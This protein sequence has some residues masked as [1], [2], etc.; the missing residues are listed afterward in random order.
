[1]A[2]YPFAQAP[3]LGDLISRLDGRLGIKLRTIGPVIGPRGEVTIRY[4]ERDA[5]GDVPLFSQPLPDDDDER[6]GWDLL[7]RICRALEISSDVL[8][9]PGLH[10]GF[11]PEM[12]PSSYH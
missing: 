10:L 11:P 8:E 4:F 3:R 5:G 12:P 7:R 1:M 6:I 2:A 9:I